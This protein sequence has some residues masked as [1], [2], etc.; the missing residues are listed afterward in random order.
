MPSGIERIDLKAGGSRTIVVYRSQ[1]LMNSINSTV[2]GLAADAELDLV[3]EFV[4]QTAGLP[5]L[6]FRQ[7][8]A[9]SSIPRN[10]VNL[11]AVLSRKSGQ[12]RLSRLVGPEPQS[13][14]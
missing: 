9:Q 14:H 3:T 10:E 4:S 1:S 2:E 12:W 7:S 8:Q 13:A 6:A 5:L 11:F